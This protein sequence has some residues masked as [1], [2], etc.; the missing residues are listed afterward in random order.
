MASERKAHALIEMARKGLTP[1]AA[2]NNASVL[3]EA[4]RLCIASLTQTADTAAKYEHYFNLIVEVADLLA[5]PQTT[6]P[7]RE[8]AP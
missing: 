7:T 5:V 1:E 6:D 2:K 3:H 8:R 4:I